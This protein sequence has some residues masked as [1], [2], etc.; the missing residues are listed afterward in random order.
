MVPEESFGKINWKD[1]ELFRNE[2]VYEFYCLK[3][4]IS[5][6]QEESV[7]YREFVYQNRRRWGTENSTQF[8]QHDRKHMARS[9]QCAC[10]KGLKIHGI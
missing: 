9:T 2:L 4:L 5:L 10:A 7:M 3:A 6:K 1:V 8:N